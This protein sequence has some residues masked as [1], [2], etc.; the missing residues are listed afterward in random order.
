MKPK[1]EKVFSS[2]YIPRVPAKE[3]EREFKVG[4]K[5][6]VNCTM[7]NSRMLSSAP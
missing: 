3:P 6:R 4:D 1:L 2:A 7:G 5:I